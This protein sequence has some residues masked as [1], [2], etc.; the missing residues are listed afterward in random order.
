MS[1]S[2]TINLT[3]PAIRVGQPT[4]GEGYM[5]VARD[6]LKAVEAL[7][8]LPP[9][10]PPRGCAMLAAHAL[11]CALKA[12]LW[13]K[14]KKKQIRRDDVQHDLVALWNMAHKEGLSIP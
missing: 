7:S 14:G 9:N 5:I 10:I 1:N 12:F 11:E 4:E 8:I 2:I 6:L 3:L 13:Q